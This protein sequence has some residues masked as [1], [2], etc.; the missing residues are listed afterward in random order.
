[1][2]NI[3]PIEEKKKNLKEYR[4]RLTVV[5]LSLLSALALINVALLAPAYFSA[6][7]KEA[8]ARLEIQNFTGKSAADAAREEDAARLAVA[9]VTKKLNLFLGA[10]TSTAARSIPSETLGKIFALKTPAI[11]I[12]SAFYDATPDREQFIITGNSLDRDSLALF[13]DALKK[14]GA[15][16]TVELPI[17]SYVKSTDIDFSMTLTRVLK[18]PAKKT[19]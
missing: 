6:F 1:M 12:S 2:L 19:K 8:G 14:D 16:T 17:R 15:F 7:S 11:K 13:V 4:L 5:A 10:S 3:L 9:D 18:T